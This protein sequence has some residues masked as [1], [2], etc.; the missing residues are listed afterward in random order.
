MSTESILNDLHTRDHV[1]E[2]AL[3]RRVA[4]FPW[5]S[6]DK[7][8]WPASTDADGVCT[9]QLLLED[10]VDLAADKL[11]NLRKILTQLLPSLLN[12]LD[13]VNPTLFAQVLEEIQFYE[14]YSKRV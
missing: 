11:D 1:M 7:A 12:T 9:G 10:V 5:Y 2:Q 8:S 14:A 4:G 13:T 6:D 3:A